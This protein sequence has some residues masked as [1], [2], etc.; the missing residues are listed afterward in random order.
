MSDVVAELSR[1]VT[2]ADPKPSHCIFCYAGSDADTRFVDFDAAVDRG[3]II[4]EGS[5]AVLDSMDRGCVC[6]RCIRV[7]AEVLGYKPELHSRQLREIRRLEI[8]NEHFRETLRRTKDEL[9][10]Q[11]DA[12]LGEPVSPRRRGKA[13]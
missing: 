8:E 9:N 13:A 2:I 1:G 3:V 4:E 11:L 10:R 7:A 6:E 5:L 12:N